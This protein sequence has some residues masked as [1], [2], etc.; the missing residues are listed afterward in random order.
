M[1]PSTHKV[2]QLS[3]SNLVQ[4]FWTG[5]LS[6]VWYSDVNFAK[7]EIFAD[8]FLLGEVQE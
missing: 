2:P 6:T 5:D 8:I 3:E 7:G 1:N 4:A